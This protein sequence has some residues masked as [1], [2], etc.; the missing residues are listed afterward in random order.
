MRLWRRRATLGLLL[1]FAAVGGQARGSF[2]CLPGPASGGLSDWA[3]R[4][5]FSAPAGREAWTGCVALG[6]PASIADLGWSHALAR[7][8]SGS[9]SLAGE[10]F[11]MAFDDLYRESVIGVWTA[12]DGVSLGL[13]RWQV[14][15][16]GGT[17]RSGWT[18]SG[19]ALVRRGR[20]DVRLAAQDQQLDR[21]DPAAPER[22]LAV[23]AGVRLNA[24][25]ALEGGLFRSGAGAGIQG[26]LRWSPIPS[27]TIHQGFRLPEAMLLSG[28][29]L[30]AGRAVSSI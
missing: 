21:R 1:L 15:W 16:Q 20:I 28:V 29:E 9:V 23:A 17:Q 6:R 10:G 8:R 22:R 12:R 3:G 5:A 30:D 27:V 11:F 4:T 25:L 14:D 7:W 18:L 13:R 2:E 19:Q 26:A 24:S